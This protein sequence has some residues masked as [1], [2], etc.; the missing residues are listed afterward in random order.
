MKFQKIWWKILLIL[1]TLASIVL[2]QSAKNNSQISK[3]TKEN[4]IAVSAPARDKLATAKS[5]EKTMPAALD[6]KQ[7]T[8]VDT[9]VAARENARK[10]QVIKKQP[11][12][13]KVV[14]TPAIEKT[15]PTK[16][17]PRLVEIGTPS[18]GP[19]KL[20][21]PIMTSLRDDYA[22]RLQ[23]DIIDATEQPEEK[24]RYQV[25]SIPTIIFFDAEGKELYRHYS[26]IPQAKIIEKFAEFGITFPE[27]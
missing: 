18:C 16:K 5:P 10:K 15:Q 23:V 1:A 21:R 14:E 8:K 12:A 25:V 19:C 22:G 4:L 20:M 17:L 11:L 9:S 2:L 13:T 6:N 26:F 7:T 3:P 24:E 27:N